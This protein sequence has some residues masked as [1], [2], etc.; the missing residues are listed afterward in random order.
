RSNTIDDDGSKDLKSNI[1][2]SR[3]IQPE[4]WQSPEV[5]E[6]FQRGTIDFSE[7]LGMLQQLGVKVQKFELDKILERHDKNK[8]GKLTKDEF[9]DLYLKL[10]AGKD[11]GSTW[12]RNVKSTAG[13]VDRFVTKK[14]ISDDIDSSSSAVEK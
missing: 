3:W 11:P 4:Q 2:E 8:D 10:R 14:D 1:R 13:G 6:K 7:V 12:N 5:E 9:E